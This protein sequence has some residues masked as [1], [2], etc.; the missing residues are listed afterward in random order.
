MTMSEVKLIEAV[1]A[2]WIAPERA[3]EILIRLADS[4]DIAARRRAVPVSEVHA[5]AEP[6]DALEQLS[7]ALC[8]IAKLPERQRQCVWLQFQVG[9]KQREIA[10]ALGIPQSNVSVHLQSAR[11]TL[12]ELMGAEDYRA[13]MSDDIGHTFAGGHG[14]LF[15]Y[16]LWSKYYAGTHQAGNG[17]W[18]RRVEDRLAEYIE[19][20]FGPGVEKPGKY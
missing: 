10:E 3:A 13:L 11:V 1:N 18:V 7:R 5:L 4:E 20:R 2:G 16:E 9:L 6:E 12:V 8:L 17:V 15:P 19:D 14:M